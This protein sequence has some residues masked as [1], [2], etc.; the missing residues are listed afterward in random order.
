M[1][2]IPF[3]LYF[4]YCKIELVIC[5]STLLIDAINLRWLYMRYYLYL[6][7]IC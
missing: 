4:R 6:W 2:W 1:F 3:A 7:T 5:Y